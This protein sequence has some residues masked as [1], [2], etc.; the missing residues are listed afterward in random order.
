VNEKLFGGRTGYW[1]EIVDHPNYDEFW[2]V[3]SVWKHA[4]NIT[5]PIPERGRLVRRRGPMGPLHMYRSI[6][7]LSPTTDNR[8]VM[9]P[10][11]HGGWGRGPG[12]RLG[13]ATF[14]V[15]TGDVFRSEIQFAFFHAPPEGRAAAG[16]LPNT[17]MFAT[18]INEFRKHDA[19]P[20][21]A[22]RR[23]RFHCRP[24]DGSPQTPGR[25][26]EPGPSTSTSAIRTGPCR[27][28]AT[29]RRA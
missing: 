18:G 29:W 7:R 11:S 6:A 25:R 26:L 10:W 21:A 12:D 3:R 24:A 14:A 4:R 15:K 23:L 19:W 2:Q 27:T 20:P 16:Q 1:Q 9:G 8:L 28:W 5:P 22:V 17:M 13:N